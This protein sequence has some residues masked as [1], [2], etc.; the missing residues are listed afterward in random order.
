MKK[1]FSNDIKALGLPTISLKINGTPFRFL[2]DSGSTENYITKAALDKVCQSAEMLGEA[3]T[4]G[5][6]GVESI[7]EVVKISYVLGGREKTQGFGVF[8]G[9]TFDKIQQ[10]MGIRIDGVLGLPFMLMNKVIIDYANL[11]IEYHP[12]KTVRGRCGA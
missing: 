11:C 10:E 12:S 9:S 1:S 3:S 8:T 5:I 7:L 2:V 4:Y 6:D